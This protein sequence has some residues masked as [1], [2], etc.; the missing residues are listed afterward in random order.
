MSNLQVTVVIP[1]HARAEILRLT[2]SAFCAQT[3]PN[4][5]EQL[6]VVADGPD[7]ATGAVVRSFMHS[8]PI[9]YVE[10]AKRGVSCARNLGISLAP[11]AIVVLLD[12]DVIPGAEFV[13]EHAKFHRERTDREAALLGYVT[14]H[15]DLDITPFMRWYGEYGGLFGYALLRDNHEADPR[16]LYSCNVSFK[17]QLLT[18]EGGFNEALTVLEDHELGYRLRKRG[19]RLSFRRSAIGYHFQTFT[20]AQSCLR[21]KRYS[22]GLNPFLKTQAG[23][24]LVQ[25]RRSMTFLVA[26]KLVCITAP[27]LRPLVPLLDSERKL[28][29]FLYRLFYW[30][31]GT[32][33]SFWSQADTS[34]LSD[35]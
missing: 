27:A 18:E 14:W 31:Y 34:L 22:S 11:S 9:V 4:S 20:F 33:G 8:L 5:L 13:A 21:L 24:A 16:F 1:T 30:Y 32:Y 26:E 23:K 12:D 3:D 2:L 15:P 17:R 6:I 19:M 28:P 29:N 7:D 35:T 25:R 10:Q